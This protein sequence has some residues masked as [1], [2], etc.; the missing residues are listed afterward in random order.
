MPRELRERPSQSWRAREAQGDYEPPQSRQNRQSSQASS[1]SDRIK[2]H[3]KPFNPNLPPA[4]FPSLGLG[5]PRPRESSPA[6]ESN[7]A[8]EPPSPEGSDIDMGVEDATGTSNTNRAEM[9]KESANSTL[10]NAAGATEA[11]GAS[12]IKQTE[13]AKEPV[14]SAPTNAVGATEDTVTIGNLKKKFVS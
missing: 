14:D 13:K 12:N 4:A 9:A 2:S 7:E 8:L 3:S 11:A 6:H 1:L 10:E 5:T